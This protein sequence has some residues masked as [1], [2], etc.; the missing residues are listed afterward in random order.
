LLTVENLTTFHELV[1][2]RLHMPAAVLP[3]TGGMPSPSWKRVY[4]LLLTSL[5]VE[6]RVFHW[7]D[8]MRAD[9]ELPT[10]WPLVPEK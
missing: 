2:Q 7:G 4:R 8:M 5:P 9:S 1:G 10:T 3:Y 6:A